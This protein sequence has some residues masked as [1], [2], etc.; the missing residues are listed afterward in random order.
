MSFYLNYCLLIEIRIYS[1]G[2]KIMAIFE[3]EKN[4]LSFNIKVEK[5]ISLVTFGVK[6]SEYSKNIVG[7]FF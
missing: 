6:N 2:L 4:A 3:A 1:I 5:L 7:P